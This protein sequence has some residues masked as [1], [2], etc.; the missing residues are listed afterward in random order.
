MVNTDRHTDRLTDS[1]H[2]EKPLYASFF[3]KSLESERSFLDKTANLF[4]CSIITLLS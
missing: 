1:R 3:F 4:L 2:E